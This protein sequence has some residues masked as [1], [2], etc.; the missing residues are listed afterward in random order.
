[1]MIFHQ[2]LLV[3]IDYKI[4]LYLYQIHLYLYQFHLYLYQFHL[5]LYQFHLIVFFVFFLNKSSSFFFFSSLK[6]NTFFLRLFKFLNNSSFDLFKVPPNNKSVDIFSKLLKSTPL[7][8][9]NLII[10]SNFLLRLHNFVK[11]NLSI[12]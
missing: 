12:L 11:F 9:T 8:F 7:S 2:F 6:F 10:S 1:M 5:Y 3:L 4:H